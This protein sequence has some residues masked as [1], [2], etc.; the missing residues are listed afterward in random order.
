MQ[1]G[2]AWLGRGYLEPY[3]YVCLPSVARLAA[4][5]PSTHLQPSTFNTYILNPI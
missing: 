5:V 4:T 2:K 3:P 1:F